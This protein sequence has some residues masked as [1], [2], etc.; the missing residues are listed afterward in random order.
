M[1]RQPA[2]LVQHAE[3]QVREDLARAFLRD[4]RVGVAARGARGDVRLEG[5]VQAPLGGL[6]AV[7]EHARRPQLHP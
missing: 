1:Q 7:H 4:G 6:R 3:G 2:R 5:V